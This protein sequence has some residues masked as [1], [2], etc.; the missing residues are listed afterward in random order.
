MNSEKSITFS[1]NFENFSI[2]KG[3]GRSKMSNVPVIE[4]AG[5]SHSDRLA[6]ACWV[7]NIK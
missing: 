4:N 2:K 3:S 7:K 5:K 6:T 1:I